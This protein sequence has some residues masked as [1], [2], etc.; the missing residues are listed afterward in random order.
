MRQGGPLLAITAA[1][2][3]ISTPAIAGSIVFRS[4]P[5]FYS[6]PVIRF[7]PTYSVPT[8]RA[9]VY[10]SPV[11][12]PS[13]SS[14]VFRST[15]SFSGHS[16]FGRTN[17]FDR[18]S[19]WGGFAPQTRNRAESEGQ[20]IQQPPP[21]Q[22]ARNAEADLLGKLNV[23]SSGVRT[24][25]SQL[26][27]VTSAAAASQAED[28][29]LTELQVTTPRPPS[30]QPDR[31]IIASKAAED[32]LLKSLESPSPTAAQSHP[33]TISAPQQTATQNNSTATKTTG[34]PSQQNSS[35]VTIINPDGTHVVN[36][37][38][39]TVV[40]TIIPGTNGGSAGSN[41]NTSQA[42]APNT[43]TFSPTSYGTIQVFENGKL[44]GTGTASFAQQFGYQPSTNAVTALATSSTANSPTQPQGQQTAF[45]QSN[46]SSPT[47]V[48]RATPQTSVVA[49]QG[50]PTSQNSNAALTTTSA[51]SQAASQGTLTATNPTASTGPSLA[52]TLANAASAPANFYQSTP[53]G[54]TLEDTLANAGGAVKG[55]P[56][57]TA[58]GN[59]DEAISLATL[60]EQKNYAQIPA[61]LTSFVGSTLA[62]NS[63][64]LLAASPIYAAPLASATFTASFDIGQHTVAP[65]V[66][67]VL[68]NAM[69]D[70]DPNFWTPA[71][72]P[73]I[74]NIPTTTWTGISSSAEQSNPFS[75]S[76]P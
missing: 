32:S 41:S 22:A 6:A 37:N 38:S 40:T 61:N 35:V 72:N 13:Y 46:T 23:P 71:S 3:A 47:S 49:P 26:P 60:V 7:A 25:E 63:V 34:T 33:I 74:T 1:G 56:G 18:A 9:P 14:G 8:F 31:Q 70:L 36:P 28:R 10:R 53:V 62:A 11:F 5:V 57:L 75:Q 73:T 48:T 29:L 65:V 44:I 16:A 24:P 55:V 30:I 68:G 50:T 39:S 27:A 58:L 66:G 59:V 15:P 42:T 21:Q 64:S 43:Y 12:R 67:P 4:A 52:T 2:L 45:T 51:V 19:P 17:S 20:I 76:Y 69:F 54:Q